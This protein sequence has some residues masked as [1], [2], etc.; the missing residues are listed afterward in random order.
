MKYLLTFKPLKNFFFGNRKTFSEDYLAISE[1]FPQNTQ[2]LGALRLFIAEQNGLMKQ[3]LNGK[4]CDNP[5][6]LNQLTGTAT[7]ATFMKKDD[8]GKITNLSSMFIVSSDLQDAY[9]P[10]PFDIKCEIDKKSKKLVTTYYELTNIDGFY[11]LSGYDVKNPSSQCLGGKDFWLHYIEKEPLQKLP[12][13]FDTVFKSKREVGIELK[14]KQVVK[15]K[16]YAK[17]DYRLDPNYLFACVVDLE[18]EILDDGIIQIGAENSLFEL[19]K[20][21]LGNTALQKHPIV[22]QLF[23]QPPK[24]SKKVVAI[25]EIIQNEK[26]NTYFS[27]VPFFKYFAMLK[28]EENSKKEY[29]GKTEQTRVAPKGSVFYPKEEFTTQNIGAY[30]KMGFNQFI[31]AKI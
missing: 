5:K 23:S 31:A 11:Y 19:K 3:F 10:T 27:L 29:K 30:A 8:L 4:W 18:E 1:Y 28:S 17:V 26:P 21:P 15:E 25:S 13:K 22:S 7:S 9:F 2:L 14:D 24:E 16:F 12:L 20:R 6:A